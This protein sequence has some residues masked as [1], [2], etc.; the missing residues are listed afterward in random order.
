M[1]DTRTDP[2]LNGDAGDAAEGMRVVVEGTANE[3]SRGCLTGKVYRA[4][5]N[6]FFSARLEEAYFTLLRENMAPFPSY[7]TKNEQG[8]ICG[9]T[10]RD[11]EISFTTIG[12]KNGAVAA[13]LGSGDILAVI[14]SHLEL[15][16]TPAYKKRH[17]RIA[18]VV[19]VLHSFQRSGE[20][21]DRARSACLH[22]ALHDEPLPKETC[23]E[24]RREN[25]ITVKHVPETAE[26]VESTR[27]DF[28]MRTNIGKNLLIGMKAV[29]CLTY[30]TRTP[31]VKPRTKIPRTS[32]A[33]LSK[34][35]DLCAASREAAKHGGFLVGKNAIV[36]KHKAFKIINA[37]AYAQLRSRFNILVLPKMSSVE[38][39]RSISYSRTT[40][41]VSMRLTLII[42]ARREGGAGAERSG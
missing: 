12:R 2:F 10:F 36:I 38:C 15:A 19:P 24:G 35:Y 13:V 32:H 29:D 3:E 39:H 16:D 28:D 30:Q 22:K 9:V 18:M 37:A 42:T 41:S 27:V 33:E 14:A 4:E 20:F 1:G 21:D 7:F 8:A 5:G 25:M 17:E 11:R 40:E 31:L 6:P 34:A 26:S 23:P